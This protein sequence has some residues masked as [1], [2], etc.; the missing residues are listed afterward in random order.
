M[1]VKRNKPE[2]PTADNRW[3]MVDV[4]MRRN[5]YSGHALIETLHTVQEVFGYIDDPSMRYVAEALNLPLSKVYGVATFYH[6]FTLKPKGKHTC[7]ICTGTACYIKGAGELV[8]GVQQ[9]YHVR[10][11]Q[12]T[13]DGQL[14][15]VSARCLGACGLAP[16]A[17]LDGQVLAN[18]T[19]D[20]LLGKIEKVLQ[21]ES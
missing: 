8:E 19:A 11:G 15:V 6:L 1:S 20:G 10:P 5:G 16:A 21:H 18:Q 3:K 14:S 4:T 13:P 9:R 12:T 7:V 17:V 2:A